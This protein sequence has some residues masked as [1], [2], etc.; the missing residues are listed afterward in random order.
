VTGA[1]GSVG[2][3]TVTVRGTLLAATPAALG[4]AWRA[5]VALC[6]GTAAVGATSG[7]VT[8]SLGD[9]TVEWVGYLDPASSGVRADPQALVGRRGRDAHLHGPRPAPRDTSDTTLSLSTTIARGA[10]GTLAHAPVIVLAGTITSGRAHGD[11]QGRRGRDARV[12]HGSRRRSRSARATRSRSTA[13][14]RR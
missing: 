9:T 12:V 14:A 2:E 11:A 6:G 5:L 7:P 13:G 8:L 4:P 3:R 1:P 10:V